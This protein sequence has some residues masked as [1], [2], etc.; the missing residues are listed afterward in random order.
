MAANYPT[1]VFDANYELT[2]G[3]VKTQMRMA[4]DGKGHFFTETTTAGQRYGT[5]VDYLNSTSTSLI[6]QGKMAMKTK[7]PPSGG[8]VADENSVKQMNGKSLG[9]KTIN[10]HPCHGY[11]YKQAGTDTQTWV[12]D[13]CKIVVE[14]TTNSAAGKSVMDLKSIAKN[15]PADLFKVPAGYKLMEQ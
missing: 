13:D 12:G 5:I 14:S 1:E 11:E 10:G 4:S 6:P 3:G 2:N 15:V 9:S 7:L 8:Y